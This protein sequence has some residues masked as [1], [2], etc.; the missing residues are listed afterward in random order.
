M[1][2]SRVNFKRIEKYIHLYYVEGLHDWLTPYKS[3]LNDLFW[4]WKNKKEDGNANY[5]IEDSFLQSNL[6]DLFFKI[7][8]KYYHIENNDKKLQKIGIYYQDNKEYFAKYHNHYD[9]S[10][11]N[12]VT[13]LD[14]PL[15]G[16]EL[17]LYLHENNQIKI[18]IRKNLIYFFPGWMMHKPLPQESTT[19]RLCFN[20][21]CRSNIPIIHKL[22]GDR[23]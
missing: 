19:S 1:P 15:E 10:D 12:C 8:Q 22:T 16:G 5:F 9:I 7:T 2:N 23:W 21:G 18:P 6:Q 20:W 11:I 17:Q 13:Y 4:E 3:R 14:P